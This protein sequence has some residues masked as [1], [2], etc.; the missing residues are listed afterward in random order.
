MKIATWNVNGIRA[1]QEQ[2]NAWIR[3]EEPDILCLQELKATLAQVPAALQELEEYWSCW[4]GGPRGYSGVALLVR[5]SACEKS[6]G[7]S[8]PAFDFENRIVEAAIGDLRIFSVYV[9][10]GGKDFKAKM[11]FCEALRTHVG[12]C[13]REGLQPVICGDLNIARQ[14]IDV[15]FKERGAF[16]GQ[17]PEERAL[18]EEILSLGMI[19][20]AREL[21]PDDHEMFT[22]WAPWRNMK[23][24]NIGWRLDYI[25]AAKPLLK[26]IVSCKVEREVGTSD[27]APV[28]AILSDQTH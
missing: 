18:F 10:N 25:L 27:H 22:W 16:T 21:H 2:V 14:Q 8:H 3:T 20:T 13:I 24:R 1:R 7:L 12:I 6:P 26:N 23:A 19:D 4:H 28:V 5:K 17:L 9:P 11:R 15:H